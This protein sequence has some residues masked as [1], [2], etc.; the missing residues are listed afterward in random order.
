MP[1]DSF[2]DRIDENFS[3]FKNQIMKMD[4]ENILNMADEV[5][6]MTTLYNRTLNF[7]GID[8]KDKKYLMQFEKP[9][10]VIA[11]HL[12]THEIDD[13]YFDMFGGGLWD[14]AKHKSGEGFPLYKENERT[15]T[16]KSS[17]LGQVKENQE[18]IINQVNDPKAIKKDK[19]EVLD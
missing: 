2:E 4:K 11:N 19:A 15:T 10:D 17:I 8:E 9:L 16:G 12:K 5:S 7:F 13:E 6:E 14:I 1:K 18:K 3:D